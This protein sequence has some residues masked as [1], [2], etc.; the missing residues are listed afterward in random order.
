MS[1]LFGIN[2][3][4]SGATAL[5]TLVVLMI[6]RGLLVPRS[7]LDDARADRDYWRAA[8]GEE[9]KA[10]QAERELTNELLEVA[11]TADHVLAALPQPASAR[12]VTNRDA[13]DQTSQ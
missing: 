1:E 12:E 7:T 11:R 9:V 3:A 5:L 6:L 8:H 4:A 13:V 2:I 10:R